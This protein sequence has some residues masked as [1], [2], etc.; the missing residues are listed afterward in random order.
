MRTFGLTFEGFEDFVWQWRVEVVGD[1]Q[2]SREC[3]KTNAWLRFGDLNFGDS[4][5]GF[6]TSGT[7]IRV[8]GI[9]VAAAF[10]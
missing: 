10:R 3:A 8:R 4:L 2:N 1:A 9:P 7:L 5:V 6:R